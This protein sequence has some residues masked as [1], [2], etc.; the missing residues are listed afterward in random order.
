MKRGLKTTLIIFI[1]IIILIGL[2]LLFLLVISPNNDKSLFNKAIETGDVSYCHKIKSYFLIPGSEGTCIG[3]VAQKN[4][5]SSICE[6]G[7]ELQKH[8]CYATYAYYKNDESLCIEPQCSK[9]L[10]NYCIING[11]ETIGDY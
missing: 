9:S 2:I 10:F 1:S 11:C 3:L 7:N 8:D 4:D 5:D 6:E